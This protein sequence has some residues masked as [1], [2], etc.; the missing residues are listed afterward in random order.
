MGPREAAYFND[1][2][3]E[4]LEMVA[5]TNFIYWPVEK[6]MSDV[7]EMYGEAEVKVGRNPIQIYG[8]I[9]LDEPETV[10]NN[11]GTETRRR[12]EI[13]AHIDRMTEVGLFPKKGDYLEW[14]SAFFEITEAFVPQFVHGLPEVKVGCTIRCISTREGTFQPRIEG[15]YDDTIPASE[16]DP[17]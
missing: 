16:E 15:S 9:Q 2:N 17:Y 8:W 13:F 4:L 11:F 5:E 6:D 14:D 10:T 3:T 7:D 1:I 12:L